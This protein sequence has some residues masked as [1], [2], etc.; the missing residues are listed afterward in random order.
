MALTTNRK[1]TNEIT[2]P[3]IF[4]LDNKPK[5]LTGGRKQASRSNSNIYNVNDKINKFAFEISKME[6]KILMNT[7]APRDNWKNMDNTFK[8]HKSPE[9]LRLKEKRQ[10]MTKCC[11]PW[12]NFES[13][14]TEKV[15]V[16]R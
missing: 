5:D 7:T 15:W 16:R 2:S 4:I 1:W 12:F 13:Y 11:N 8:R 3:R 14:F 9:T 6:R 10:K